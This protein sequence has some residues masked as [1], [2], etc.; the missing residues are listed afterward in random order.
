[1]N[2]TILSRHDLVKAVAL[3][4]SCLLTVIL[5]ACG[6][7]QWR[8]G[9]DNN[10]GNDDRGRDAGCR[11]PSDDEY[12]LYGAKTAYDEVREKTV[13]EVKIPGCV[14]KQFWLLSRHGAR[15]PGP[16]EMDA[17]IAR[18]P[19]LKESIL[20]N[21]KVGRGCL[22]SEDLSQLKNW[23]MEFHPDLDNQ[24]TPWGQKE[25]T[26]LA[27]RF[28]Q[29]F[30][31]L[32]G[33]DFSTDVYSFRHTD[34]HRTAVS[35]RLFAAGLFGNSDD[36][37][38]PKPVKDDPLIKFYKTCKKWKEEVDDNDDA[39]EERT[40][41]RNGPEMQ[42]VVG[43][44]SKRLGYEQ[45]LSFEDVHLMFAMCRFENAIHPDK[46]SPWCSVFC[47]DEV[48]VMEYDED[49]DYYWT[50]GYGYPINYEQACP[51]VKDFLDHFR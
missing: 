35:A 43:A 31:S 26:E 21:A 25:M 13:E 19:A 40:R 49:L 10:D 8:S 12:R 17:L 3:N 41:F 34:S 15:Y 45:R 37:C 16:C 22:P 28:K 2:H 1:M 9:S 14:P 23:N 50:D 38:L 51:P 44:V 18:L 46:T 11:L 7:R 48:E 20:Q 33:R 47:R 5:A 42:R 32:L 39:K 30:P 36:I 4:V 27:Q 29:R 6:Y 24:L